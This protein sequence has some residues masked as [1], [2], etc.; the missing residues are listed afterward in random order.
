MFVFQNFATVAIN[1]IKKKKFVD[2]PEKLISNF[3]IFKHFS[4]MLGTLVFNN[5]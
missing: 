3:K 2:T 4:L 1:E 5:K